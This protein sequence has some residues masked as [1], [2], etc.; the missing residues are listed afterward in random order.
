MYKK[1]YSHKIIRA[2]LGFAALCSE[3]IFYIFGKTYWVT[4]QKWTRKVHVQKSK[5]SQ[6]VF[7]AFL[8][9][10]HNCGKI[11]GRV[12]IMLKYLILILR[13]FKSVYI[14]TNGR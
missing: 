4:F 8:C 2:N 9:G 12:S 5:T 11:H 7:P 6:K 10:N 14:L 3:V 13:W 1:V